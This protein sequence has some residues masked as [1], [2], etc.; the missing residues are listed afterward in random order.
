LSVMH[1]IPDLISNPRKWLLDP[2]ASKD[3]RDWASMSTGEGFFGIMTKDMAREYEKMR[4]FNTSVRQIPRPDI[5]AHLTEVEARPVHTTKGMGEKERTCGH[6]RSN[7]RP[8]VLHDSARSATALPQL[9]ASRKIESPE[10]HTQ[11]DENASRHTSSPYAQSSPRRDLASGYDGTAA[12]LSETVPITSANVYYENETVPEF[13]R[14]TLRSGFLGHRSPVQTAAVTG[15]QALKKSTRESPFPAKL[16]EGTRCNE[17]PYMSVKRGKLDETVQMWDGGSGVSPGNSRPRSVKPVFVTDLGARVSPTLFTLGTLPKVGERPE[18]G[19]RT[20]DAGAGDTRQGHAESSS[21]QSLRETEGDPFRGY[22]EAVDVHDSVEGGE[23]KRGGSA[24]KTFVVPT[25]ADEWRVRETT[26]GKSER[27]VGI[28]GYKGV[29][30]FSQR[31]EEDKPL[32]TDVDREI[33]KIQAD[34]EREREREREMDRELGWDDESWR[35]GG[36]SSRGSSRGR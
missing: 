36:L 35:G 9:L 19:S 15:H 24:S 5:G 30:P 3:V 20:H 29:R 14:A 16:W 13:K 2:S 18:A 28:S 22:Y 34:R 25:G 11:G 8:S 33:A 6:L 23:I 1:S 21:V 17:T 4:R 7:W 10:A 27:G 12:L 26:P 31:R 32:E